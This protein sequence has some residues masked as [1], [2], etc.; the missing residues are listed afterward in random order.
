MDNG[1]II[2]FH[3][4]S[5]FLQKTSADVFAQSNESLRKNHIISRFNAFY[6][7]VHFI[8]VPIRNFI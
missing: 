6:L 7:F 2:Y 1:W 8:C 5:I 4:I 3:S